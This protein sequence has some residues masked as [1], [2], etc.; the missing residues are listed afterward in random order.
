MQ[1]NFGT[2]ETREVSLSSGGELSAVSL[3]IGL[4]MAK[5]FGGATSTLI[6]DEAFTA[7]DPRNMDATIKTIRSVM[8]AQQIIIIAHNDAVD[9]V[10][11]YQIE[12]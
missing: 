2:G 12:L 8:D 4:A 7:Y 9:V 5:V 11:D 6:L 3:A 10:A 1:A